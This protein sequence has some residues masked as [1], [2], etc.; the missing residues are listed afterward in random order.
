[1]ITENC[2]IDPLKEIGKD[3][4]CIEKPGR[5]IGGEYGVYNHD[6]K[7]VKMAIAFPD[8]YEIGMSNQAVKILYNNL[9]Q[10]EDVS[11]DRVFAPAPD[12]EKL[13]QEKKLPLY[14]LDVYRPLYQLDII[15]VSLGYELGVTGMLSILQSGWIPIKKQD[16]TE[17]HPII[18]IG[19]PAASNPIP[20][21][22]F[23][24]AVWIG[25][26]EDAF[27]KLI[28]NVRDAKRAGCNRT[29]ILEMIKAD[30]AIWVPGKRAKR[31]IDI[32]FPKSPR[33]VATLPTPSIKVV[34]D[35]GTIE[36]MRGCPNGCRFCH[37]GIWYR[38]T[39]MKSLDTIEAEVESIV[40]N[41]GYREITLSSLSSGDFIGINELVHRLNHKY[42]NRHI[43]FQLPSLKVSTFSLP[44]L[45][46]IAETRKSGLTFAIETPRD[47]WQLSL[48]KEVARENV[49]SILKEAKKHG[50]KSAKFYFMIGLPIG[51][52]QN[53]YENNHEEE[54]IVSF[55]LDIYKNTGVHIHVNIGTFI[56]KPHTP[57]QWVPQISEALAEKKLK[58]IRDTLRP[59]GFKISTHDPF[60]SI[61]EGILS[62]GDERVGEIIE[63][64]FSAGCRLDAWDDYFKR[65]IWKSILIKNKK[66]IDEILA[67][68]STDSVLPWDTV[69]SRTSKAFLLQEFN[70]SLSSELTST[71]LE[72]CNHN[73]GIC[74]NEVNIVKNSIHRNSVYNINLSENNQDVVLKTIIRKKSAYKIVFSFSKERTAIFI[75]HLSLVETFSKAFI[76]AA[77]PIQFTEG[78]NPLPRLDIAAPLSLGVTALGEIATI[79]IIDPFNVTDFIHKVNK[80][81]P[82]D[83]RILQAMLVSI[84]EGSKKYTSPSLLW[85]YR[86][87]TNDG[88]IDVKSSDDKHFRE[89]FLH[90]PTKSLLDLTRI[91]VLADDGLGSYTDY[92]T[93]Y[94][95]LYAAEH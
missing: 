69:Y 65:D 87:K 28:E 73:C 13:L 21:Q 40:T 68:F 18:I 6:H 58:Y 4:L 11:C 16:R 75:P 77:L 54:E 12:F 1:M 43:S 45:E 56:P 90:D 85:G 94:K 36:I 15:G 22:E 61:I 35:H 74:G 48:N 29:G 92:F 38:P 17:Q 24:D 32:N 47:A 42:K 25:E 3:F 91:T 20:Y 66:I 30:E 88:F 53:G 63:Q 37:A 51:D 89:S 70:K 26:A 9:N 84:P 39:R 23:I 76:R 72:Y 46:Q 52:F 60:I 7:L 83:I 71:C 93:R 34:Q 57:Y 62:R 41:A 86:Y 49:I 64:A 50:W 19:G 80:A 78:F 14:T 44:L 81:L 2:T 55:L 5:Y 8:L 79:E 59:L 33:I 82:K 31:H 95:N 27:F 10:L 67:G